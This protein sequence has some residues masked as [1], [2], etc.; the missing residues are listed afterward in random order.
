MTPMC[1]EAENEVKQILE[2]TKN[3]ALKSAIIL[4]T[5]SQDRNFKKFEKK[6][7][8]VEQKMDKIIE[9]IEKNGL[10]QKRF[11]AEQENRINNNIDKRV[12]PIEIATEELSYLKRN[13]KV[14]NAGVDILKLV[15]AVL[16]GLMA[17]GK[18]NIS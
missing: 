15:I 13:P 8:S 17:G 16:I 11:C 7:D 1:H 4:S 9:L 18:L 2:G 14:I 6:I 5:Q 12:S 10:E 3:S